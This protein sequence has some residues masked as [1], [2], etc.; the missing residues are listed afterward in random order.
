MKKAISALLLTVYL[1]NIGGKLVLHQYFSFLSDKFFNEQIG[2]GFY[3]TGDLTEVIL[4]VNMPNVVDWKDYEN[5]SGQIKFENASYNYVKMK[6]TRTALYLMCIPDY[7]TTKL[8]AQNIIDVKQTTNSPI[9]KK[10]HVPYGKMAP[11]G[12]FNYTFAPF[13]FSPF[14]KTLKGAI[15]HPTQRLAFQ[16]QD[17]PWQPPKFS[18]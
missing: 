13:A 14:A 10:S 3:N 11:A 7:Q 6:I 15:V 5:I 8:S 9:P 18:C 16:Y 1:F 4:P 2:K 17:T 12:L